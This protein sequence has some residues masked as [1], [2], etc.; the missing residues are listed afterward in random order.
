MFKDNEA[1]GESQLIKQ[2]FV[3]CSVDINKV[4]KN[5]AIICKNYYLND[6]VKECQ[7][8]EGIVDVSD[9]CIV[10]DTNKVIYDFMKVSGIKVQTVTYSL[11][12]MFSCP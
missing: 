7:T 4:T 10:I 1:C 8:N 5:V 12:H 3:L 9:Q 6:I 2:Q 11:S